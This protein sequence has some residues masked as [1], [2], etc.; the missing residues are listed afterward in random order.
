MAKKKTNTKR[1]EEI[2][3]IEPIIIEEVKVEEVKPSRQE[4][5]KIELKELQ[6]LLNAGYN[7]KERTALLKRQQTLQ[8]ELKS[9]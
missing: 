6:D 9:L 1:V 4:L 7:P 3:V 5:I 8:L 2:E